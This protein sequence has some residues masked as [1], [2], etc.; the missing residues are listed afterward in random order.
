[1]VLDD[2]RFLRIVGLFEKADSALINDQDL[3]IQYY[4]SKAFFYSDSA[5][6]M[7]I[8]EKNED[9]NSVV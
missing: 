2:I 8:V 5:Q 6:S 9:R 1:M 3:L 7:K 4:N